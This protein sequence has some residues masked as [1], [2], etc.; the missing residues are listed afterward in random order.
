MAK[1]SYE[2]SVK[3]LEKI[4]G[5]LE[6]G[7]LPLDEALKLFEEGTKLVVFCNKTLDDAEQKITELTEEKVE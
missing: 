4:V 6:G 3:R 2:D 7:S 1:A 5:T